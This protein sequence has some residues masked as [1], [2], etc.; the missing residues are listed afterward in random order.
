MEL[1]RKYD[2]SSSTVPEVQNLGASVKKQVLECTSCPKG[3]KEGGQQSRQ[4][5]GDDSADLTAG[6]LGPGL[7]QSS[8]GDH[9]KESQLRRSVENNTSDSAYESTTG[10]ASGVEDNTE[11]STV[12]IRKLCPNE[13][14]ITGGTE[15]VICLNVKRSPENLK[16]IFEGVGSVDLKQVS[17]GAYTGHSPA[18]KILGKVTVTVGSPDGTWNSFNE[19][20]FKYHPIDTQQLRK[21]IA[22]LP[23]IPLD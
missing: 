15:F 9:S 18:S 12:I 4:E 21:L 7:K 19:T 8:G 23:D 17:E 13:G 20:K 2:S 11:H 14:P 6:L 5:Q 16:A 10:N 3:S 1:K 22:K